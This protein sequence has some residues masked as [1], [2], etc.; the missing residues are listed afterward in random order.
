M[1]KYLAIV[2]GLSALATSVAAHAAQY[3]IYVTGATHISPSQNEFSTL[4]QKE[5]LVDTTRKTVELQ[6]APVCPSGHLCSEMIRSL[7]LT[8]TQFELHHNEVT[9][10]KAQASTMTIEMKL[11]SDHAMDITIFD[12]SGCKSIH[13]NLLGAPAK[14]ESDSPLL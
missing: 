9:W 6:L 2:F 14:R 12:N 1:K 11:N 13:S 3:E 4:V 8:L 5:I 7:T 10:V